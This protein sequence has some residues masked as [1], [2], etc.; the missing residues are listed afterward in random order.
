[1]ESGFEEFGSDLILLGGQKLRILFNF[2]KEYVLIKN[3]RSRQLLLPTPS[4]TFQ[5]LA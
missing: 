2:P 3:R 5:D 4:Q 1:M